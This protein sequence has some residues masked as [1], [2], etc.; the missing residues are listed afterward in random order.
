MEGVA[1][2]ERAGRT[3]GRQPNKELREVR[4]RSD[5]RGGGGA[6]LAERP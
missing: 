2:L 5:T 6:V 1:I 4:S 3:D